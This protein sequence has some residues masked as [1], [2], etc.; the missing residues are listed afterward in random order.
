MGGVKPISGRHPAWPLAGTFCVL[1]GDSYLRMANHERTVLIDS[2]QSP[3]NSDCK[4]V[5]GLAML[6]RGVTVE[7]LRE[8]TR[9]SGA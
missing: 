9:D 8:Q 1:L 7:A 3:V 2:R 5:N 6:L 4:A